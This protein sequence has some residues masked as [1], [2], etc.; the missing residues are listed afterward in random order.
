MNKNGL[1]RVLDSAVD[2]IIDAEEHANIGTSERI[3][4]VAAG[5][6]MIWRGVK[7]TFSKP[8]NTVW[9]VILGGALLYRGLTGYCSIK[10]RLD[11]KKDDDKPK[12]Y[13][14]EAM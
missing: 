3:V 14:V 2:C 8:S 5:T 11:N 7:D 12:A 10:N 1:N 13:L 4:S 9:E 6:F